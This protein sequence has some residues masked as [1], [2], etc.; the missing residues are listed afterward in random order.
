MRSNPQARIWTAGP[1]NVVSSE[2]H[3]PSLSVVLP[4]YNAVR[5]LSS[6]LD[7]VLGASA[8]GVRAF[9]IKSS[10]LAF[11]RQ[12]PASGEPNGAAAPPLLHFYYLCWPG[13]FDGAVDGRFNRLAITGESFRSAAH[14]RQSPLDDKCQFPEDRRW[15][16]APPVLSPCSLLSASGLSAPG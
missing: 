1:S 16:G 12:V 4:V 7:S 10:V 9:V 5:I 13:T 3:I 15:L 14:S 2:T 6:A 11:R 8:G